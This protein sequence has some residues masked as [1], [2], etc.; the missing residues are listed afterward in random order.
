[1]ALR[2]LILSTAA[3]TPGVGNVEETLKWGEPAYVTKNGSGSTVRIDWK[4][5]TPDK[6]AMY[7][8]C[9]TNLV[10]TFRKRFPGKFRF[11]GDRAL[12][13]GMEDVLP[14]NALTT[15]VAA[16]LTYHIGKPKRATKSAPRK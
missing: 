7:F 3:T 16:A 11:D 4:A 15:C 6:Y 5:R 9:R 14:T 1:M 12:V 10:A 8:H 2:E 13:F